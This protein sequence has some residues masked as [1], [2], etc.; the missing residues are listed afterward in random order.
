MNR[1]WVQRTCKE[2]LGVSELKP[3]LVDA[4]KVIECKEQAKKIARFFELGPVPR[5]AEKVF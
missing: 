1:V 2:I 4:E 5:D 3:M